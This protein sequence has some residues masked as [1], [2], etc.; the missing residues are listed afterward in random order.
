MNYMIKILIC[1]IVAVVLGVYGMV[2]DSIPS[3]LSS[4]SVAPG[5]NTIYKII[6]DFANSN[7]KNLLEMV[8]NLG[9]LF[10]LPLLLSMGLGYLLEFIKH[11]NNNNNINDTNN[12]ITYVIP[13]H[14]MLSSIKN[15]PV[16]LVFVIIIVLISITIFTYN[17]TKEGTFYN[18]ASSI[19]LSTFLPLLHIGLMIGSFKYAD[20]YEIDHKHF[21]NG[22]S[23]KDFTI[24]ITTLGLNILLLTFISIYFRKQK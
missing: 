16:N 13:S 23:I 8:G 20:K 2:Y 1:S 10:I 9:I 12:K 21:P 5:P 14:F 4:L 19:P 7:N 24:P 18:I 11:K 15:D 3:I 6:S 22:Q 17:L